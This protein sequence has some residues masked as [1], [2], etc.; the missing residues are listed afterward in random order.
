[1]TRWLRFDTHSG[2][3]LTTDS[4]KIWEQLCTHLEMIKTMYDPRY[5]HDTY[6]P[7]LNAAQHELYRKKL[8]AEYQ[9]AICAMVMSEQ[10]VKR[11]D[12]R[13]MDFAKTLINKYGFDET[14]LLSE[15]FRVGPNRK[16]EFKEDIEIQEFDQKNYAYA[17]EGAYD[18]YVA[19]DGTNAIEK[20][21][22]A[23][24]F[25]IFMGRTSTARSRTPDSFA[26]IGKESKKRAE[27]S[28]AHVH[29]TIDSSDHDD[30]H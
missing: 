7:Q 19:R 22:F 8:F 6:N 15:Y 25:D 27:E 2:G 26:D 4:N 28:N 9:H 3:A 30:H 12:V 1:M 16:K 20:R 10:S 24:R 13:Y 5:P 29:R 21:T 18:G 17:E 11:D 23:Q 14:L